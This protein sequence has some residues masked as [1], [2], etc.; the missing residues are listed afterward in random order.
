M[1]TKSN[2]NSAPS[3]QENKPQTLNRSLILRALLM[4]SLYW[5]SMYVYIPHTATFLRELSVSQSMIGL[6]AGSYGFAQIFLRPPLGIFADLRGCA[7]VFIVAGVIVPAIASLVRIASPTGTGFLLGNTLSGVGAA[8]WVVFIIF[9]SQ[10]F[11]KGAIQQ[12]TALIMGANA[13]GQ[14]L[15]FIFSALFYNLL[16]MRFLCWL[17]VGASVLATIIAIS[18]RQS[19]TEDASLACDV[20]TPPS[21]KSA[22][23]LT[24]KHII[25]VL[26]NKRLWFFSA[27]AIMQT[28]IVLATVTNFD[29]QRV[30]QLGGNNT[31]VGLLTITFMVF[32]MLASFIS[33]TYRFRKYGAKTWVPLCFVALALYCFLSPLITNLIFL[34]LIQILTGF[35]AGTITSFTVAEATKEVPESMHTTAMG[36]FQWMVAIGIIILPMFSGQI[37]EKTG[38]F[39][40]AFHVIGAVALVFLVLTIW[41]TRTKKLDA[42]KPI[43]DPTA[44]NS[45]ENS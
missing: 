14:L 26:K 2:V 44:P 24:F 9:F 39:D 17:S 10:L 8:V 20:Q 21:V 31:M 4:V 15:G 22:E 13:F 19:S 12:A 3:V 28:G 43:Y 25:P 16:G 7:K 27:I 1:S 37:V 6:V 36:I 45:T 11:G 18:F 35:F 41:G 30:R 23:K 38:S 34:F 29:T 42:K 33:S 40:T 32:Q 5:F